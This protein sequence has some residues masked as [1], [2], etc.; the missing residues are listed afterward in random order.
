VEHAGRSGLIAA[1]LFRAWIW[2]PGCASVAQAQPPIVYDAA[3]GS[4]VIHGAQNPDQFRIY[5]GDSKTPMLGDCT[6][7]G[8]SL[9]FTPR[10]PF[11]AGREYRAELTRRRTAPLVL[12]FTPP[13]EKHAPAYVVNIC[14]SDSQVP[15]NLLRFYAVFSE[16]MSRETIGNRIRLV[17]DTGKTVDRAL[18]EVQGGLWSA[19]ATRLTILFE[20]GRIK[21]GLEMH[22][23]LGLALVPGRRYRL[24]IARDMRDAS[25]DPLE[26]ESIHEFEAGPADRVSPDPSR[27]WI[28]EPRMDSLDELTAIAEKPLDEPLFERLVRVER[29]DGSF[30][31]GVASVD[32]GGTTWRFTPTAPWRADDRLRVAAEL[33]DLAGNRPGRLFD[34]PASPDG[35]HA[36]PHDTLRPIH[37]R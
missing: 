13:I 7:T 37:L 14:P 29:A 30:V 2:I 5:F 9:R 17:D 18:L 1:I 12:R 31:P 33:E 4:V 6:V 23:A 25:G 20:P 3:S 11:L 24:V 26:S 22:D 10:L 21:R 27:W 15:A 34:Q 16:P 32:R 35:E 28:S 36:A 8:Q 19:D